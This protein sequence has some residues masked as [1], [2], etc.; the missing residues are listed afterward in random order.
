MSETTTKK[1]ILL[2]D[3]DKDLCDLLS[4]FLSS[5]HFN[6]SLC[7]SGDSALSTALTGDFDVILLDV[8]LPIMDGFEV[9]K[10]L[11]SQSVVPVIMLTA[12]DEDHERVYGLECGADDYLVKPFNHQELLARINAVTRRVENHFPSVHSDMLEFADISLNQSSRLVTVANQP[13]SLT[14]AEFAVLEV[15]LRHGT[16]PCDK[17]FISRHVFARVLQPH[18]RSIDMH[19]SNIRKKIAMFSTAERVRTIR[20]S[21]YV[22]VNDQ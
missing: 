20:G 17:S 16:T 7:H 5:K 22:L 2:I 8:M 19:V 4:D 12:V 21:G 1:H 18:D 10:K 15:L 11:R 13:I 14:G 3:D 6:V 9:L